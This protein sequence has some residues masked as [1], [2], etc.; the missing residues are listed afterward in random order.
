M[1]KPLFALFLFATAVFAQ[2]ALIGLPTYDQ[3]ASPGSDIIVQVQRPVCLA[4]L[5]LPP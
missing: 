1:F 5:H 4:T 2:R 3:T